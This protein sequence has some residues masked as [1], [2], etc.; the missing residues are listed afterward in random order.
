MQTPQIIIF[1]LVGGR[2]GI[3]PCFFIPNLVV[4]LLVLVLVVVVVV[5]V[6]VVLLVLVLVVVVVVGYR[7]VLFK[8]RCRPAGFTGRT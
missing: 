1:S 7:P 5:V 8:I 2:G 3:F 4:V 6:V